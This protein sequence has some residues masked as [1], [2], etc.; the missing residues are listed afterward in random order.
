MRWKVSMLPINDYEPKELIQ[1]PIPEKYL[2]ND[3]RDFIMAEI[4]FDTEST[5]SCRFNEC[6]NDRKWKNQLHG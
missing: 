2:K 1:E 3:V 5:I 6:I 4:F